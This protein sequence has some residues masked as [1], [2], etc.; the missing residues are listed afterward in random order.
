MF[1]YNFTHGEEPAPSVPDST[2][3]FPGMF[4]DAQ[5]VSES[6]EQIPLYFKEALRASWATEMLLDN[7]A[8]LSC[9]Y[10][11]L[12]GTSTQFKSH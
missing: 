12:A 6:Q 9:D 1:A 5:P 8:A 4:D 7:N 2:L 10:S 3:H 11:N